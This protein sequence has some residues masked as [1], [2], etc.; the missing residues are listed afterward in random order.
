MYPFQDKTLS[1]QERVR[2]LL[3]RLTLEEKIAFLSTYEPPVERLGIGE[4][5]IGQEVARGLVNREPD[6]PST[7]FPQPIG[8][9]ATFDKAL[10]REIG[11]T[12]AREAR[13]YYNERKNSGLM[14]W[15]PTVDLCRDPRWGRTEE[16]YGEDPCLTGEMAAMYTKGLRGDETVWATIPTLKHFCANN[17]EQDRGKDNAALTPRLKH[18]YYYAAF[19]TPVTDGG[20]HS[21]MTAYNEI[22]H[23][24]AVMDHDL[25][26]ILKQEWGLGLVV[27]DGGDF[28]QNLTAHHVFPS[29]AQCLQACLKAGADVMTDNTACVIAAAKKAL[30]DGLLTEADIDTA[31][32]NVLES[33]VL[34][35]HF[36]QETPFDA[37]TR[38][39]VNT[40]ADRALDLRAAR[41]QMLLLE[42]DGTLPLSPETCK[43][44]A[45]F[46]NNAD[47]N[48]KDWYT[49]ISTYQV[50]I[51]QGLEETGCKVLYDIGWDIV[52]LQA[53]NGHY[54]RLGEDG[55]LYADAEK[56]GAAQFYY[57][58][59]DAQARWVD[60]RHVGTGRFL[61]IP[62]N[63][64]VLGT[65]EVYG[66]FTSETLHIDRYGDGVVLSDYLLGRQFTLDGERVVCRSKARP[67]S[68]VVFR[69]E[70]IS[71]GVQRITAL[72]EAADAIVYCGGNDPEQVA[73]ECYD[74][75]TLALPPH[76]DACIRA[77][78]KTGRPLIFGIVSSY[79]YALGGLEK[80]CGAVL[81]T[82]HAGPEL[83]HAFAETLFG[84]NV[85]AGR[86]PLTWYACDADLADIKDYDIQRTKMTYRWFD[87]KALYPFGYGLSYSQFRYAEPESELTEQGVQI[88]VQVTNVSERDGDEVVQV[89]ASKPES[90]VP[91][92]SH[93]LCGFERVHVPAGE[94]VTV[95]VA[96]PF[97]E[98]WIYDV[99]REKL[100]LEAGRYTFSVGASSADLRLHVTL[101]IPGENIPPRDLFRETRAELWDA[102]ENT[103][104]FTD[105]LTGESHVRGLFWSNSLTFR[106]CCLDGAAYLT[107]RAAAPVDPLQITVYLDDSP[108]P[109]AVLTFPSCDGYTDLREVTVPLKAD[110]I[111]DVR[112]AFPQDACV[113]SF[114]FT[115]R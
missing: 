43:T 38:A 79:P 104:I 16:C 34:L 36:D 107:L 48:L 97:R 99:S 57:C 111:H 47:C 59:H 69:L 108:A 31:V 6:A 40:D 13:A 55:C 20:A 109:A 73:R 100:C 82:T 58:I 67:D 22:C 12:A 7:V 74:R 52:C 44:V 46:G 68:R 54:V 37:L 76:Q 115:K 24:P 78:A 35:G 26:Q 50:S 29:H 33:R 94:T 92:S 51:K 83:G 75:D 30:A 93:W 106:N 21:V 1:A 61:H 90:A 27:T 64:P 14:V 91:R 81:Y 17:H 96:V 101:D 4:W 65:D 80:C 95:T 62:G 39:D 60:L 84:E 105:P 56:E 49:G 53:P 63:A 42:N 77:L 25:K 72:A 5:Y 86:C 28:V 45:L 87:G 112:L 18:E 103:E 10:M 89:Y 88:T 8:L 41:E 102:Q 71:A 15:G 23:A 98:L 113:Q 114:W 70:T 110:G 3:E 9:A 2:D 85:P 19:R 66:W 11:R 32:G